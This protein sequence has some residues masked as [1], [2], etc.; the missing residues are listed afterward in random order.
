ML[1]FNEMGVHFLQL[2]LFSLSQILGVAVK[3]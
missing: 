1:T 3:C 2:P